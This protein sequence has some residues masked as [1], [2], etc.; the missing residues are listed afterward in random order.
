MSR[1]LDLLEKARSLRPLIE[2]EA[3]ALAAEVTLTKPVIE[4]DPA[5]LPGHDDGQ[6]S[7]LRGPTKL[8]GIREGEAR[9]RV[10]R[11]VH[12]S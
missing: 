1:G 10:G 8:R 2:S 3:D 12:R 4:S 9:P 7:C 11:R 6:P 5:L